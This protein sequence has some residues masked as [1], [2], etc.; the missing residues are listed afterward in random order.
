MPKRTCSVAT[1]ARYV[2]LHGLCRAHT[3]RPRVVEL[4]LWCNADM[5][6]KR[7]NATYCSK[8]CRSR[9]GW[10]RASERRCEAQ[11]LRN[12]RKRAEKEAQQARPVRLPC[13]IDGCGLP[14]TGARIHC[15]LHDQRVRK[16]GDPGPVGRLRAPIKRQML[17]ELGVHHDTELCAWWE[18]PCGHL[19]YSQD[20]CKKHYN[21]MRATGG[22]APLFKT[23]QNMLDHGLSDA[24]DV[25]FLADCRICGPR[26]SFDWRPSRGDG[27][28]DR[29]VCVGKRNA[30]ARA[31]ATGWSEVEY[32]LALI[33]QANRCAICGKSPVGRGRNGVLH[34]DHCHVAKNTR[35]LLCGKCNQMIGI[36]GDDPEILLNAA[37]YITEHKSTVLPEPERTGDSALPTVTG[38]HGLEVLG[39]A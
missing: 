11:Q 30:G 9:S 20:L 8:L 17:P 28:G 3:P 22:I 14:R 27:K 7:T 10:H 37:V 18:K 6:E 23:R 25:A 21:R 4:C 2:Q 33:S 32:D 13:S 1:C 12:E 38:S 36:A 35:A 24:D 19:V 39:R 16:Y 26:V 34:A 15:S 5:A 29:R 31:L